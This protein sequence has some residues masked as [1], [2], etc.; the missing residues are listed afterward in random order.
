MYNIS[1]VG[2]SSFISLFGSCMSGDYSKGTLVLLVTKGLLPRAVPF[3]KYTEAAV[4]M[5]VCYRTAFLATAT[6][7]MA[8]YN[9]F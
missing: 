2:F 4:L 8:W 7:P 6:Q 3:A 1:A 9:A 5:T